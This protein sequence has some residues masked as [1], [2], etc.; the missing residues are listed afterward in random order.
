MWANF[1]VILNGA[2]DVQWACFI[3]GVA[4]LAESA[5]ASGFIVKHA[6]M[7]S[8]GHMM[9]CCAFGEAVSVC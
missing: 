1:Y 2:A 5:A 3:V 4:W 7:L 9:D 6:L 8:L